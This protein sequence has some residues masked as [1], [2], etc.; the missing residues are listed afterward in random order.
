MFSLYNDTF[1]APSDVHF[2][3][4]VPSI[5]D[6]FLRFEVDIRFRLAFP[7]LVG[8]RLHFIDFKNST[9]Y[10]ILWKRFY[11]LKAQQNRFRCDIMS[12]KVGR[13]S[14]Y[15]CKQRY[16]TC[17]L[18][19][20]RSSDPLFTFEGVV[21]WADGSYRQRRKSQLLVLKV[22]VWLR[23]SRKR[24]KRKSKTEKL[25]GNSARLTPPAPGW[26]PLF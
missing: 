1:K 23:R 6:F 14:L 12:N 10:L 13:Y 18:R 22:H 24:E 5:S 26:E 4:L 11:V 8:D 21:D 3:R 7:G 20:S 25:V 16:D 19:S 15:T 9:T 2:F 17:L